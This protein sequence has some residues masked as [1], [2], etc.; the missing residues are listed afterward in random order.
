[1]L[2]IEVHI[3]SNGRLLSL[4]DV[5]DLVAGK[6]ANRLSLELK[7]RS[8]PPSEVTRSD[9]RKAVGINEAARMLGIGRSTLWNLI[10]EGRSRVVRLGRRVLIPMAV[11]NAALRD[12]TSVTRK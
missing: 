4:D 8:V 7:E 5:T 12:G 3:V 10:S 11:I 6:V 2:S 1:M 9:S